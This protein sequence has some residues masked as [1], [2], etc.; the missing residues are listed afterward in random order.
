[1]SFIFSSHYYYKQPYLLTNW[2]F[3]ID[4]WRR[5]GPFQRGRIVSEWLT[6]LFHIKSLLCKNV[7]SD[8]LLLYSIKVQLFVIPF[9]HCYCAEEGESENETKLRLELFCRLEKCT[10]LKRSFVAA[11]LISIL[12]KGFHHTFNNL[13]EMWQWNRVDKLPVHPCIYHSCVL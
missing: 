3:P 1:M 8:Y 11:K 5:G 4:S 10:S 7:F 9:C 12:R 13:L 2:Y 6:R